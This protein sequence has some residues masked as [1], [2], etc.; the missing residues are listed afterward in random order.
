MEWQKIFQDFLE[1]FPPEVPNFYRDLA[2]ANWIRRSP[3]RL[4][5]P[6]LNLPIALQH[7]RD[8]THT[9]H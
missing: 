5:P 6:T 4:V 2:L 7:S 1:T 8:L 3:G 9:W